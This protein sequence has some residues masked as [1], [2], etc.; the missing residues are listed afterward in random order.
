MSGYLL[1]GSKIGLR[2]ITDSDINDKYCSWLNDLEVNQYMQSRY[3]PW[4]IEKMKSYIDSLSKYEY[5]FAICQIDTD[6]HIGNIKIGPV[7]WINRKA[8]IS[9]LL[10]EKDKWG[11]GYGSEAIA[12][13]NTYAFETLSLHK[14]TAGCYVS[15]IGSKNIFMKNGYKEEGVLRQHIAFCGRYEDALTFGILNH[16][17]KH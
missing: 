12:L 7:D 2:E 17:W 15:N 14:L 8:E 4:N 11:K 5:I 1:T 10:G 3:S 16:E 13:M 9:I 6:E